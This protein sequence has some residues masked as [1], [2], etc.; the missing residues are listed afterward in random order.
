MLPLAHVGHYLWIL[1]LLPVL[2]VVA[3]IIRGQL[4][5]QTKGESPAGGDDSEDS[6][7]RQSPESETGPAGQKP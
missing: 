2:F 3:A 1:Y 6:A 4:M 5:T 7:E